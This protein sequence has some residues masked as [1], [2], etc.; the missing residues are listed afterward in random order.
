MEKNERFQEFIK[1]LEET[2]LFDSGEE[3]FETLANT[4]NR[5]EDE[6][7][8]IPY[9][10]SQWMNDGRMYPPQLDNKRTTDNTE[11]MRYRSKQHNTYIGSNGSIKIMEIRENKVIIDKAGRDRRTVDDL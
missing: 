5:V 6:F 7:S 1:R 4:L 8:D 9:S 2:R 3:A 10:P 11:V